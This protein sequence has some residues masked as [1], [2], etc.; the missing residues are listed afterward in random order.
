MGALGGMS[1]R[2]A[3][4][5][6]VGRLT[7]RM[8]N[9]EPPRYLTMT[10]ERMNGPSPAQPISVEIHNGTGV[11]AAAHAEASLDGKKM[12]LDIVLEASSRPGQCGDSDRQDV[13]WGESVYGRSG[14]GGRRIMKN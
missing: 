2:N 8:T 10:S 3:R 9:I 14:M 6:S 11:A 4:A 5:A 1:G 13:V 12:E 7:E